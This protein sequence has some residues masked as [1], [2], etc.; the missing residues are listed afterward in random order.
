[1]WDRKTLK[2]EA[3]IDFKA[4]YWVSVAAALV[5]GFVSGG[6][7]SSSGRSSA[8]DLQE[9]YQNGT[10]DFSNIAL[11]YGIIVGVIVGIAIV[12]LVKVFIGNALLVGCQKV[13]IDN[14]TESQR[15]K[16]GDIIFV[17]KSGEWGNVAFTMFFKDL[18]IFLWSLLLVIPGIIKSYEY[19]MVPYL[20]AEDPSMSRAEAFEKSSEMMNGQK[21]DT[22]VLDLS[23]IGWYLLSLLTLGILTVFY[24]NPYYRQTC[25]NQYRAL[26]SNI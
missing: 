15:P 12:A 19:R 21:W 23:F 8:N 24:V 2:S 17:F 25:A 5:L 14:K 20:L 4:N 13:F 18:L 3:K 7:G 6:G 9:K 1:M 26:K 10:L 22:F 16:L 11:L